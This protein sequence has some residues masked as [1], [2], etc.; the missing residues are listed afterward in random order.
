MFNKK[1]Q[2]EMMRQLAEGEFDSLLKTIESQKNALLKAETVEELIEIKQVVYHAATSQT[3]VVKRLESIEDGMS[4]KEHKVRQEID[5]VERIANDLEGI[6]G[7]VQSVQE[8]MKNNYMKIHTELQTIVTKIKKSSEKVVSNE[9]LLETILV[10]IRNMQENSIMMKQQ[11]NTFIDTAKNVSNNMAGIAAIAEQTNLLA[12]NASIEAARAGDAGRGFAVVAEEIRKLSDGTKV[13][14]DDMTNFIKAFQDASLK[15]NEEVEATTQGISK[16]EK[17]IGGITESAR[18]DRERTLAIGSQIDE[19]AMHILEFQK[20]AQQDNEKINNITAHIL[21][22]TS[23]A[24]NLNQ[25]GDEMQGLREKIEEVKA[26]A[27][28]S[29]AHITRLQKLTILK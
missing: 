12:L 24:H 26:V 2:L 25:V 16:V 17:Q 6:V 7:S 10:D 18:E 22:I 27:K 8:D 1:Q 20:L 29:T 5:K 13:L 4:H 28:E 14:L 21:N 15:T 3:D 19:V 23:M 9:K 11:V